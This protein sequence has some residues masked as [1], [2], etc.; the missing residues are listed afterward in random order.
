SWAWHRRRLAD[1]E[2]D[3]DPRLALRIKRG[4]ALSGADYLDFL[5]ERAAWTARMHAALAG[6]DAVLS[7]TVQLLA[8][9][10]AALEA[11]DAAFFRVNALLLRNSA[12]VNLLDGCA[13]GLPCH[14]TG[15]A[16]VG[17]RLW[18]R[19]LHDDALLDTAIAVEV[20]LAAARR[21]SA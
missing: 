21:A 20:V 13:I 3:Y 4:A 10:I 6:F 12:V 2:A 16:P 14:A 17:L 1:H 15:S 19:G 9:P 18:S 7:P 8:P 11:N 5:R